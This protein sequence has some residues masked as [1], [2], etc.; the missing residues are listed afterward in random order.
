MKRDTKAR[1]PINLGA[2]SDKTL[3]GDGRPFDLVK[4]IPAANGI[5]DD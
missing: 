2:A 5:V 1:A 3:G 4:D